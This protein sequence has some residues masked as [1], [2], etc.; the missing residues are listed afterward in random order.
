M[1]YSAQG[2]VLNLAL[3]LLL[4]RISSPLKQ[5]TSMSFDRK[6][7]GKSSVDVRDDG[8]ARYVSAPA[9]IT[10]TANFSPFLQN[11]TQQQ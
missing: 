9:V 5:H 7:P 8:C 4:S 10:I 11:T 2:P 6:L 3:F 1:E